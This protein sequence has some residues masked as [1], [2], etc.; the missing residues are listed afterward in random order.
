MAAVIDPMLLA[1]VP[2]KNPT[3]ML[4]WALMHAQLHQQVT[5]EA[6]KRNHL[7]LDSA[8]IY[9]IAQL[10]DWLS[11]HNDAHVNIAEIFNIQGP[12][13]LSYLDLDDEVNFANWL[14]AHA[15]THDNEAKV[16]GF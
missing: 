8:G 16:I 11:L 9:D 13:D 4:D 10:E 15:L 7:N 3:A 12:P 6:V 14:Q 2:F 1:Y 5:D